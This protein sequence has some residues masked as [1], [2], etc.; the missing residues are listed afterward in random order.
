MINFYSFYL[1]SPWPELMI[2]PCGSGLPVHM[3]GP[4]WGV[5]ES[6]AVFKY[7]Y[8]LSCLFLGRVT[9][10]GS[11]SVFGALSRG[12]VGLYR[13]AGSDPGMSPINFFVRLGVLT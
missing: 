6:C 13:S 11:T 1:Y 4:L 7:C 3:G 9:K 2:L 8:I 10:E 5:C 12:N